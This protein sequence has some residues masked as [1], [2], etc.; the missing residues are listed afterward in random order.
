V[1]LLSPRSRPVRY[2]YT[3]L[4][5]ESDRSIVQQ[6]SQ[7]TVE[8]EKEKEIKETTKI[9]NIPIYASIRS[10]YDKIAE[11]GA[12]IFK[13]E[14]KEKSKRYRFMLHGRKDRRLRSVVGKKSKTKSKSKRGRYVSYEFPKSR[15][16]DIA[17]A[18]TLRAAAPY[19]RSREWSKLALKIIP[20][21]IRVKVRETKASLSVILLL[22]MSESMVASLVNMRNAVMSMRDIAFRR[23]DRIGLVVFKGQGATTIQ[24]PTSNIKLILRKLMDLGASNLTPLA[25]GL[26]EASRVIRNETRRNMNAHPVL[27][28]ISDGITNI[29]LKSPLNLQTR[30]TFHNKAQ[31]DVVDASYLLKK[32]NVTALAINPSHEPVG[33]LARSSMKT[34][35]MAGKKWLEP[36]ELMMEIPRIT[37]GYY[38]GIGKGGS[39]EEVVLT[40]AFSILGNRI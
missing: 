37:G 14:R 1:S 38:Y 4:G 21:D 13:R 9:L 22:D 11:K 26:Y 17:M 29:P 23:R 34:A 31:A 36:T 35:A 5:Q 16:W 27:V 15:P 24:N 19:Q 12:K 32:M 39:L 3:Y 28:V 6:I 18:P 20:D 2:L 25:S 33:T 10:L 8:K 40:E 7:Y 30:A